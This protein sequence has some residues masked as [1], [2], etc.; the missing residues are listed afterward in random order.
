MGQWRL[1]SSLWH[2]PF[3]QLFP[4]PFLPKTFEILGR[5][6]SVTSQCIRGGDLFL[7]RL[8]WNLCHCSSWCGMLNMEQL[9]GG[10]GINSPWQ[11]FFWWP[12]QD[13]IIANLKKITQHQHFGLQ[14]RSDVKI[15]D[16]EQVKEMLQH[17]SQDDP[18]LN[19]KLLLHDKQI[20]HGMLLWGIGGRKVREELLEVYPDGF[21]LF[22]NHFPAL[23]QA[24]SWFKTTGWRN[25]AKL[26]RDV[27]QEPFFF[28]GSLQIP[29]QSESFLGIIYH[30][31]FQQALF[32]DHHPLVGMAS[33]PF[34]D[35]IV[36]APFVSICLL[37]TKARD[38]FFGIFPTGFVFQKKKQEWQVKTEEIKQKRGEHA[39]PDAWKRRKNSLRSG[40][41]SLGVGGTPLCC[42]C[43]F[44]G[45]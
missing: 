5:E 28:D 15:L 44:V 22:G 32:R 23:K 24:I 43:F 39:D 3:C 42:R 18:M 2:I 33:K 16:P 11:F 26:R 19:Y 27:K 40:G 13:P 25:A 20:G 7:R 17:F 10:L 9:R 38:I 6:E 34:M 37:Q 21:R 45:C 41:I 29:Q 14:V 31:H 30:C 8:F 4:S 35:L 36:I 1:C 12:V